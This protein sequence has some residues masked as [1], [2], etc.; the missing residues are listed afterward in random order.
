MI[1]YTI[2]AYYSKLNDQWIYSLNA[3]GFE[4]ERSLD[5]NEL[6]TLLKKLETRQLNRGAV[7]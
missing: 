5:P 7:S 6:I 2:T 3:N 4:A 1:T